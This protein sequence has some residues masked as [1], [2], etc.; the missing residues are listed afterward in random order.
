MTESPSGGYDGCMEYI[1][2]GN[3]GLKLSRLGFGP[4]RLPMITLKDD[5]FVDLDK[6]AE[7]IRHA[8][9]NGVNYID[10]GF[11]YCSFESEYAVG[12]ALRGEYRDKV[13][14][15]SKATKFNM[16]APGDLRR[17]LDHQLQKLEVEYFD[18]YCFHGIGYDNYH[19]IDKKTG[20][21]KDMH[22]AKEEGLVK[23]IAFSFHDKPENMIK[24]IDLGIF[25][26]VTCQY[27]YLDQSNAAGVAHAHKKG[28]G[29]VAMGPVGG[30][31][32]AQV[33]KFLA[34]R[35]DL[36]V[37]SAAGLAIRFVISNPNIH[38]ALS[39]MGT[40]EMVD[41]NIAAVNRGSLDE[42]ER[43]T[44]NAMMVEN[45]KLADLYCTACG[46]CMPCKQG[47]EIPSRFEAMNY[48]K[49]YGLEDHAKTLYE[50]TMAKEK[51]NAGGGECIECGECEEKCPQNIEIIKQLKETVAALG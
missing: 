16:A 13:I 40:I 26:M 36:D 6:A 12:R 28:L 30:G 38:I 41:D 20:W 31:R 4:M 37:S 32:L 23:R 50:Q 34:E 46:Y 5:T 19:E 15:N 7:M 42:E 17:M 25:E 51:G 18:F 48:L 10:S 27:N 45:K 21:I 43:Q 22:R 29:V 9:D 11:R 49:V 35:G 24:L 2:F 14:L 3:T 47:V 8:I 1:D 33:P 44:I 39:G